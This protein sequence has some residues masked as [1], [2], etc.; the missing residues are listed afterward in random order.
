M[1]AWY[2]EHFNDVCSPNRIK[3]IQLLEIDIV[4]NQVDNGNDE[5]FLHTREIEKN[6]KLNKFEDIK[7][8]KI[9]RIDT[10]RDSI[11]LQLVAIIVLN[12]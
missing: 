7:K 8:F 4:F 6:Q 3:D 1:N 11:L 10:I 9:F 12:S 2:N 5:N